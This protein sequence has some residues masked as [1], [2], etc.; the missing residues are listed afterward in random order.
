MTPTPT[1]TPVYWV[2]T[3]TPTAENAVT[4]AA[5][6][7]EETARAETTGTATAT[8]EFMATA[9]PF[10]IVVT[11]TP[12]AENRATAAYLRA[13]GTANVILTGTPT[14]TPPRLA[15][16]TRTPKPTRTPE[17]VWLDKLTGTPTVTATPTGTPLPPIPSVLRGKIAFLSDRGGGEVP[18]VYILDPDTMR[19]ALLTDRWPYDEAQRLDRLSPDGTHMV[20][21]TTGERGEQIY[22]TQLNTGIKWAITFST[23]LSYDPAWSPKGD[24]IAYVSQ[25]MGP[26]GGSDE[27]FRVNP[28]G[29]EKARLTFNTWEWDK[30]PTFSP[31]GTQLVFWSNQTKGSRQLWIMDVDGSNRR[32]LLDSPYNDWDPVW[33]K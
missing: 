10:Y 23:R 9:T 20:S 14:P 28:Q 8:P 1:D 27:I 12:T 19:V 3:S 31:D 32:I 24:V 15:T 21:V 5:I 7:V 11:N 16:A 17:L 6:A 29:S 18:E 30:H 22:V 26:E 33:I 4:A 25:E 13:L 2:V